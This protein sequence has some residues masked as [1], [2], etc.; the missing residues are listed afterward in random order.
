MRSSRAARSS[1]LTRSAFGTSTCRLLVRSLFRFFLL[2]GRFLG[3]VLRSARLKFEADLAVGLLHEEGFEAA[4]FLRDE[5]GE[6]VGAAG[7]EQLFHLLALDRLLQDH[8]AGAEIAGAARADRFLADIGHAVLENPSA[9]FGARA[10]RLLGAEI[11][12]RFVFRCLS[13]IK[14]E[15]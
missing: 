12:R 14:L 7:F 6:Q 2:V 10:E 9:A 5:A 11:G 4:A 1:R 8:A 15:A 13:E 3:L